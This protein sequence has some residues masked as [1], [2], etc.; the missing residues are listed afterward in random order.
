VDRMELM[1][2]TQRDNERECIDWY[3]VEIVKREDEHLY[4]NLKQLKEFN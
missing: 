3:K 1:N 2:N 4:T